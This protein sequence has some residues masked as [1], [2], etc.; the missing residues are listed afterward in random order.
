MSGF[1]VLTPFFLLYCAFATLVHAGEDLTRLLNNI[2]KSGIVPDLIPKIPTQVVTVHYTS[3]NAVAKMGN[4][5]KKEDAAR[6]P[7]VQFEQRAN[8][9]YTIMMLDPDAPSRKNP[10]YRSWVH[11]LVVNAEGPNTGRVDP[12]NVIQSYKGPGPPSGTGPHRYV[13]FVF[14]QGKRR[15]NAKTIKGWVSDRPGFNL[16]KFRRRANL[17][18]PFATNF[19]FSETK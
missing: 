15:L 7:T 18:L 6:P 5:I 1:A 2:E 11:W 8:N 4:T 16:A 12:G 17:H 3:S 19:Y 14:C 10:K 9:L 13:F